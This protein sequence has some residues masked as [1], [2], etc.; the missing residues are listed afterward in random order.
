MRRIVW[1]AQGRRHFR[2]DVEDYLTT[3][4]EAVARRVLNDID[5]ALQILAERPI[6]RPGR[7]VGT[8]EKSVVGQPYIVTYKLVPRD[9]GDDDILILRV[10][11][12]ARDWPPG[13]WPT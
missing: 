10:I 6:G 12:T 4:P 11:H 9:D 1:T 13:H 3:L 5:R 2:R 7:V 8:Y